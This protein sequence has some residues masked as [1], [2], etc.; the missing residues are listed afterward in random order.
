MKKFTIP[1]VHHSYLCTIQCT[2]LVIAKLDY[3]YATSS[4]GCL[5]AEF[6]KQD[7]II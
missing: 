6:C 2:L 5:K 3:A 7:K 4:P 1:T